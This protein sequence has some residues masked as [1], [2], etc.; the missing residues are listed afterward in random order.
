MLEAYSGNRIQT[1]AFLQFQVTLSAAIQGIS[2]PKSDSW[3]E[4]QIRIR[5]SYQSFQH[6]AFF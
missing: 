4:N 3:L 5:H 1:P 6:P 2:A